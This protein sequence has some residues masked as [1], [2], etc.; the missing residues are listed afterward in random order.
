M[1][2]GRIVP[3]LVGAGL[4]YIGWS[5]QRA[6]DPIKDL[7]YPGDQYAGHFAMICGAILILFCLATEIAC[8]RRKQSKSPT[9]PKA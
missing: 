1:L 9:E 7:L 5:V 6:I 3:P 4:I 8:L 2:L